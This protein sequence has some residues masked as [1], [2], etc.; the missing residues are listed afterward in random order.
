MTKITKLNLTQNGIGVQG[1]TAL[2]EVLSRSNIQELNINNDG[3]GPTGAVILSRTLEGTQLT[4]LKLRLSLIRDEGVIAL[5]AYWNEPNCNL[6]IF[7]IMA[8]AMMEFLLLPLYW[9][10]LIWKH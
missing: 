4:C 8:L 9:N 2:S 3:F 6:W 7:N 5:V 10:E 1:L